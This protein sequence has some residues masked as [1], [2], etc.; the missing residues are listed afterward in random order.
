SPGNYSVKVTNENG[1]SSSCNKSLAVYNCG[2]T[3][4]KTPEICEFPEGVSTSVKFR[5][6]IKNTGTYYNA[7][8]NLVDDNATPSITTDDVN[9]CSWGPIA[10]GDSAVCFKTFTMS[11]THTN[12]ARA[13]GTSGGNS[14][15]ATSTATVAGI[16][17]NC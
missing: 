9:V 2:I 15:S 6:V 13:T 12:T 1:C 14:V 8:G 16:N 4:K 10:P 7:S 17:C 3:L 11:V 5:Y